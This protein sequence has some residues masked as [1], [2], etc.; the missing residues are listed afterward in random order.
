MFILKIFFHLTLYLPFFFSKRKSVNIGLYRNRTVTRMLSKLTFYELDSGRHVIRI[1]GNIRVNGEVLYG[2]VH[3]CKCSTEFV[4][5]EFVSQ[6][7]VV[8]HSRVW[9]LERRARVKWSHERIR[10]RETVTAVT[11]RV[12][13]HFYLCRHWIAML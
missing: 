5:R 12:S 8:C 11:V 6:H 7:F 1:A 4:E 2:T 13:P 10:E 3:G 9:K